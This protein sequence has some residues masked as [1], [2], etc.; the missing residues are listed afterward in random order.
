MI[1]DQLEKF[2]STDLISD[3]TLID[4]LKAESSTQLNQK[5]AS[6]MGNQNASIRHPVLALSKSGNY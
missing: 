3:K 5:I 6:F 1:K 2:S 4:W